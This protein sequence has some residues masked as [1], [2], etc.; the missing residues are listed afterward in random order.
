MKHG[1]KLKLDCVLKHEEGRRDFAAAQPLALPSPRTPHGAHTQATS[2]AA[3][4]PKQTPA[5]TPKRGPRRPAD[6]QAFWALAEASR[7]DKIWVDDRVQNR[8]GGTGQ[9]HQKLIKI[10]GFPSF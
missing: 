5:P 8:M 2:R 10:D 9:R 6:D 1:W 3:D 4:Q 7:C